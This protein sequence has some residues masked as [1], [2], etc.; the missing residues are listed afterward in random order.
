MMKRVLEILV[1]FALEM[2]FRTAKALWRVKL[3][4]EP[5][6][7]TGPHLYAHWHGD[8]LLLVPVFAGRGYAVMSSRS[9]DGEVMASLLKR[10]GY[11]VVRGSSS[12]GGAGGLKG[13]VDAVRDQKRSA[14]VAVDGPRGPLHKV[15]PGILFLASATGLPIVPAG[16]SAKSAWRFRNAWNQ[17]YLPRPFSKCCVV[18]GEPLSVPKELDAENEKAFTLRLEEA[19]RAV[20]AKAE[21]V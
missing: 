21:S 18:F 16:A 13:L 4:N 6:Q 19:L 14:A 2:L 10:L 11:T 7:G 9:R 20:R 8:E 3:V 1:V 12:R 15:K 17:S 5:S